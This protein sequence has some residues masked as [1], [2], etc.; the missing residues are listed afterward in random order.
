MKRRTLQAGYVRDPP[1]RIPGWDLHGHHIQPI[2][3]L[4]W[5]LPASGS[6]RT[7]SRWN[8]DPWS[9]SFMVSASPLLMRQIWLW[10]I[11]RFFLFT[12]EPT[13]GCFEK[14]RPTVFVS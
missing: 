14:R 4:Y 5:S 9:F 8:Y 11:M 3:R 6:L 7:R 10:F 1:K 12:N 2:T 13:P